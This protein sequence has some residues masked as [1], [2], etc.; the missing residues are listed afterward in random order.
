MPMLNA[1]YKLIRGDSDPDAGTEVL[2]G[3]EITDFR[4]DT[5]IF[6]YI[7]RAPG[8]NS[9]GKIITDRMSELYPSVFGC[10]IEPR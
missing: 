2:P 7:S 3:E 5:A 6:G 8:G 4:G 9:G 10:T 1:T